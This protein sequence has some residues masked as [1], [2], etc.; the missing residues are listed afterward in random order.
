MSSRPLPRIGRVWPLGLAWACLAAAAEPGP[1]VAVHVVQE[2]PYAEQGRVELVLY[3]VVPQLNGRFT[4]HLGTLGS[5]VWHL[6]ENFGLLLTG[7]G[8]WLTR[9]SAFNAELATRA[10]V[11]AQ[12]ASSLLWTWG[13][14]GGVEVSPL[15]GKFAWFDDTLLH[16][17]VVI[18]AA[19]GAGGTRHQLKP[20][21]TRDDGS[22]SP[23]SYG[24]TGVKFLGSLS[25]GLRLRLGEHLAVRLEV[26][27]VVYTARVEQVNGCG[28]QDLQSMEAQLGASLP[29][30]SAPVGSGCDLRAF[31]GRT[32]GG[33]ARSVDVPLAY[34]LVRG[35]NGVPSSDVLNNIGVYLGVS[36]LF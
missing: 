15:Y 36:F 19:A 1:D 23:A 26:R 18:S 31:L 29:L 12:A 4:D 25:L 35:D 9:E 22:T 32:P 16:F 24:D 5:V 8:N 30:E 10:Q 33:D 28:L 20:A 21:V 14:L 11:S 34:Q 6:Q 3:P 7:G 2:K 17:S 27:D 13:L